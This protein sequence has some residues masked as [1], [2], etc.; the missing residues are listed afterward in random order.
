MTTKIMSFLILKALKNS[1]KFGN[2]VEFFVKKPRP[3]IPNLKNNRYF[4]IIME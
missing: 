3:K 2:V 4:F 1:G